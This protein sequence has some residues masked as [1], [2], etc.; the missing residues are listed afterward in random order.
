MCIKAPAQLPAGQRRQRLKVPRRLAALRGYAITQVSSS[1]RHSLFLTDGG[2]TG[3]AARHGQRAHA[4]TPRP[5]PS[6]PRLHIAA[7]LRLG[8]HPGD[9]N[10]F[11][12]VAATRIAP[13]DSSASTV[14]PKRVSSAEPARRQICL[15]AQ[16][17][18]VLT[19]EGRSPSGRAT[20]T[21]S[22]APTRAARRQRR[23][24]GRAATRSA[25]RTCG[26]EALPPRR[27]AV[28]LLEGDADYIYEGAGSGLRAR[29]ACSA[30]AKAPRSTSTARTSSHASASVGNVVLV[31]TVSGRAQLVP[32]AGSPGSS[33]SRQEGQDR[34]RETTPALC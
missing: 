18:L 16:H 34:G 9:G 2:D 22:S 28:A 10:L 14:A 17:A 23:H 25:P 6:C 5:W 31:A 12:G 32:A 27:K 29:W 19:T 1:S 24:R 4:A 33:S 21:A 30:A 15:E 20:P 13:Q 11:M 26:C 7:A 8:G 3:R